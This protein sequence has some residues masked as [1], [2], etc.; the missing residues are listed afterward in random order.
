MTEPERVE[1]RNCG[2][3]VIPLGEDH[4]CPICDRLIIIADDSEDDD[5]G[6]IPEQD[7][8][9]QSKT[10]DMMGWGLKAPYGVIIITNAISFCIKGLGDKV[11]VGSFVVVCLSVYFGRV[12]IVGFDDFASQCAP[13]S[14]FWRG[15]VRTSL[16]LLLSVVVACVGML[17]FK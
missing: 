6:V 5:T 16:A 1:C 4:S 2:R 9:P 17:I 15:F 7:I 3:E 12:F 8:P 13:E 11:F 10:E 14:Q